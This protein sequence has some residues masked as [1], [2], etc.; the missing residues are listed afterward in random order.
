MF[1]QLA[2][3]KLEVFD[4]SRLLVFEIY[5][6]TRTF[7]VEEKFSLVQQIRR[8]TVSVLLNIA[9]GCSR[10]SRAERIRFFIIS[11]SSLIELDT[12]LDIASSLDYFSKHKNEKIGFMIIK[13]FKLLCGL[14]SKGPPDN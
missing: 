9:E 6:L 2:H 5:K 11:R 12:A 13:I 4:T 3:T 14:I 8:A 7:P 10:V 1:L